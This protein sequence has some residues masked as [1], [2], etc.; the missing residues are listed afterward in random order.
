M[1]KLIVAIL[2]RFYGRNCLFQI[3]VRQ[4]VIEFI[5]ISIIYLFLVLEIPLYCLISMPNL[6][7]NDS[8]HV[9]HVVISFEIHLRP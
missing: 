6:N 8:Q 9:N 2:P 7:G 3:H 4:K 5:I 1:V